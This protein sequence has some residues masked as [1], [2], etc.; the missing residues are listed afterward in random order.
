MP[1]TLT[2]LPLESPQ[3]RSCFEAATDFEYGVTITVKEWDAPFPPTSTYYEFKVQ[4]GSEREAIQIASRQVKSK[5]YP[6]DEIS[7]RVNYSQPME[8]R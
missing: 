4:A 1:A 6:Y 7:A 3:L 8:Q 5:G 2:V